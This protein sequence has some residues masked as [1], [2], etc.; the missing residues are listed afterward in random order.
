[1]YRGSY[2]L[3]ENDDAMTQIARA[4]ALGEMYCVPELKETAATEFKEL[5]S[6][7]WEK[8][9]FANAVR[10]IYDSVPDTDKG[11]I[12]E[13]IAEVVAK[14]YK[15]L[16]ANPEFE[17]VLDDFGTL[18]K[19]VLRSLAK[20]TAKAPKEGV[21]SCRA[22]VYSSHNVRLTIDHNHDQTT[23]PYCGTTSYNDQWEKWEIK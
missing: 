14:N 6:T 4:Y 5:S 12:R 23:C 3:T 2:I 10:V 17:A 18:G 7:D 20:E 19:D 1:M 13:I 22:S 16:L 21:Y 15:A 8:V 11:S 9:D